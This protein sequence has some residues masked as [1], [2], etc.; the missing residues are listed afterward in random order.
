MTNNQIRVKLYG[1]RGSYSPTNGDV[2]RFGVNT[3]CLRFDIGKHVVIMDAGSGLINLGFDL[4]NEMKSGESKQN[5]SRLFLFFTHTHIDHLMGFPYFSMLYLPQTELNVISPS[6]LD[7][8]IADILDTWMSPAFF[9]VT[10]SELP[11]TINFF[12]F[13]VNRLAYFY[14]DDFKLVS[15]NDKDEQDDSWIA[16]ISCI[17]NFTHPKGGT[18][19]YK[20]ENRNGNFVVFATDI[21]GFVGG[22]QRLIQFARNAKILFH[23]AQYSLNEYQMFQGFGHST[24]EMACQ[25]AKEAEVEKLILFHHDP[26]HTD[27]E[28]SELENRAQD[29]FPETYM[30]TESMEFFF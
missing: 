9:P 26:R 14:P 29:L 27:Q 8:P 30:A 20:I 22:D 11:S 16:R 21:E 17:R 18:Y 28:L 19:L 7:Y 15:V 2:T 3:T 23:D 1:V 12:D 24:Y 4:I 25:V 6:I 10:L 5:L 13:G